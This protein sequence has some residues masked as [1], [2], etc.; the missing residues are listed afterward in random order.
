MTHLNTQTAKNT[1]KQEKESKHS[2]ISKLNLMTAKR[3]RAIASLNTCVSIE[4][5]LRLSGPEVAGFTP[6]YTLKSYHRSTISK[7]KPAKS[8]LH[9]QTKTTQKQMEHYNI[10]R[11]NITLLTLRNI[12]KRSKAASKMTIGSCS[13]NFFNNCRARRFFIQS[14]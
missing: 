13:L 5:K 2:L 6:K 8:N 7:H 12:G 4:P 1:T 11:M 14:N 10:R 3:G 9:S